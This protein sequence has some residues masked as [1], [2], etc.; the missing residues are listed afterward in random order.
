MDKQTDKKTKRFWPPQRQVKSELLQTWHGDR[1]LE[2]ILASPKLL[3]AQCSFAA[4]GTENS[5]ETS[6]INLKA[7]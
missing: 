4:R 2:H 3:R 5:A 6:P 7:P 1:D